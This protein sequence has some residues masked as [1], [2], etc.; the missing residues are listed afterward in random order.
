MP[1]RMKKLPPPE[2]VQENPPAIK[3]EVQSI[4]L[5]AGG[6]LLLVAVYLPNHTGLLGRLASNF[7]HG[8]FGVGAVIMPIALLGLAIGGMVKREL[9]IPYIK[10]A[11]IFWFVL[12]L[13]HI[14]FQHS[15]ADLSAMARYRNIFDRELAHVLGGGV[16]GAVLGDLAQFVLF[17]P[18]AIIVLCAGIIIL[19]VLAS[20]RSFVGFLGKG[21]GKA[22][23]Y[24]ETRNA[25]VKEVVANEP[26]EK[27]MEPELHVP[28]A[29]API[30]KARVIKEVKRVPVAHVKNGTYN[31][32]SQ[33]FEIEGLDEFKPTTK[34]LLIQEEIEE[35]KMQEKANS[36]LF[37]QRDKRLQPIPIDDLIEFPVP[38]EYEEEYYE[39]EYEEYIDDEFDE[40]PAPPTPAVDLEGYGK[41]LI[42]KGLVVDV[43]EVPF[44]PDGQAVDE[45]ELDKVTGALVSELQE[46]VHEEPDYS[47]YEL[48]GINFLAINHAFGENAKT[49]QQVIENSKILEDTLRSFKIDAKVI[50]VSVGPA[51][52]RYDL[53]PGAGVKVSSIVNLSNDLA[54]SLAAQGIRIEAPIP[55]KSAV[56][57]EIPNKEAQPVF[58]REIIEDSSF[59]NFASKLAFG[60]GKDI[61]GEPVVADIARMPHLLIAGA[62]GSGKSVCINT[63]IT[64]ILYKSRP[65]EVKL[66]MI[67]PK[68]VEL[69]VYNGIPHLLI[70]VVTDPKKA[71]GALS[72]AVQEMETRYNM[73]AGVG[74]RD[75][76]GYNAYAV[77]EG[78][79][80]LPQI[81][82]IIDEL[83]DLMMV[84]K[85]E[86]E[87]SIC[88]LAQKARAAGIHLIVATQRPSVD[89]ITGLIKANIPSRLA[90]A[91]SSGIDS[92][93]VIDMYGAEK[94]LGRGDMLFLPM[95]QNKP[96]RV[97][98]AF[99]SDKEV[100]K[101]VSF[102][103]TQAPAVHTTEMI[104]QVTMPGKALVDGEVD[105]FF[106]DAVEFLLTKG[107]ASTS[108]LQRQFRIGYN[109]ASRLMEDLEIRGI[110]GPEDG[111]K[112][113]KVT[114]TRSEYRELY[115]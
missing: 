95:G 102:L 45:V 52:T 106:H 89:V 86:V 70:P 5:A 51:V 112:P 92:R 114:I 35:R 7:L 42:V 108:M 97:Q 41:G 83:A 107:K 85:S 54:L 34:V 27:E 23:G 17:V 109:R 29:A 46:A 32:R 22:K 39:D 105:E 43:P 79:P 21:V 77:M 99:I 57:I 61:A 24:Y 8:V 69:S 3:K 87:E 88:R 68:V 53:A 66:L 2:P 110:V 75:L 19:A 1:R 62:T 33:L 93:T 80:E 40:P 48:P 98:G 9:R 49:R 31:A 111:V 37:L 28:E 100:E 15:F 6:L 18:G 82:I 81:V 11:F 71:S 13:L 60:V 44:E 101:V 84:A 26:A 63:L 56:G 16:F 30:R 96:I 67:D 25:R 50:E 4:S 64:S 10:I 47:E 115:G 78:E 12:A 20:G 59:V 74:S 65:D 38:E 14:L 113:R 91:V 58:L 73:F 72:W 103:K 104:Q 94:L 55:G 36:P 76:K 90:F